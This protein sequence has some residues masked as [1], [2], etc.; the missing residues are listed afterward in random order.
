MYTHRFMAKRGDQSYRSRWLRTLYRNGLHPVVRVLCVV[1]GRTE[2]QRVERE[3]IGLYRRRGCK[4]TNHTDGGEGG[5]N[6]DA[7]TRKRMSRANKLK[8][9]NPELRARMTEGIR[10][11]RKDP[12]LLARL[13]AATKRQVFGPVSEETKIKLKAAW[14]ERRKTWVNPLIGRKRDPEIGRRISASKKGVSRSE[15]TRAKI[16]ATRKARFAA[17]GYDDTY[18]RNANGQFVQT[19]ENN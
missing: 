6:P 1:Q 12:D 4:L 5:K 2:A 15:E 19:K 10:R 18:T 8:W 11:S 7:V 17:G 3:L 9:Q 14:V 16:S 13:S